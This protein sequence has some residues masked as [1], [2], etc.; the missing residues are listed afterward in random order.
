MHLHGE[1]RQC[2]YAYMAHIF[3][4][5]GFNKNVTISYGCENQHFAISQPYFHVL[6]VQNKFGD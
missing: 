2:F 4:N 5:P 1:L 3:I 6:G